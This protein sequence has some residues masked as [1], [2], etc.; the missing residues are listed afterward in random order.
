MVTQIPDPVSLAK[1]VVEAHERARAHALAGEQG[2]SARALHES[3]MFDEWLARIPRALDEFFALACQ[4]EDHDHIGIDDEG[5]WRDSAMECT[6]CGALIHYDYATESYEHDNPDA[7][8]CSLIPF[9]HLEASAC[10]HPRTVNDAGERERD[11]PR[12]DA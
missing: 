4:N 2:E 1:R 8:A 11:E 12:D 7:P 5:R 9:R 10:V 6:G 3:R